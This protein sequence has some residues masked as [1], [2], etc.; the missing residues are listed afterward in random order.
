MTAVLTSILEL[1]STNPLVALTLKATFLLA[2]GSVLALGLRRSAAASRH[3][4]WMLTLS[5]VVALAVASVFVPT[6]PIPVS[7]LAAAAAPLVDATDVARPIMVGTGTEVVTIRLEND[8][9][10]TSA[11]GVPAT[12]A[13]TTPAGDGLSRLAGLVPGIWF[14]GVALVAFRLLLGQAGLVRLLRGAKPVAVEASEWKDLGLGPLPAVRFFRSPR[15]GSPLTWGFLRPVVLLPE[16]ADSW[17]ADRRRVVLVHELAHVER[18]DSLAQ[19]IAGVACA[20]YWFHPLVWHAARRL[21]L[22][23]EK[24]CDDRVLSTGTPG[25]DYA[26]HLIDVARHSQEVGIDGL[27][28]IG[29]ARRSQFEGRLLA[30]L[31]EC[32]PRGVPRLRGRAT[33]WVLSALVVLPLSAGRLVAP[34]VAESIES[35]APPAARAVPP[36]ATEA[37]DDLAQKS[38][39]SRQRNRNTG[40][41]DFDRTLPAKAGETLILNLDSGGSIHVSGWNEPQVSV[42]VRLGGQDWR[43]TEIEFERDGADLLLHSYQAVDRGSSS[44]SHHFEI[45]VP[46][47]FN[48]EIQSAGGEI[49]LEDLEGDFSGNTGGGRVSIRKVEGRTKITTGGGEIEVIDSNLDGRVS[50]G[51]GMVKLSRVRGGLRG[52]SGSGPVIYI[53][54]EG[55]EKED[56]DGVEIDVDGTHVTV[57]TYGD[58][59][60]GKDRDGHH[61]DIDP[62]GVIHIE[63]AG[64]PIVLREA[65]Q[66]ADVRTGGGDIRVGE[67]GGPVKA[68]TGGGRIEIGPVS[69]PVRASTGSGDIEVIVA[70]GRGDQSVSVSSGNGS[71]VIELPADFSGAFELETAYTNNHRKTRIESDWEL[72]RR[73][74]EHWDDSHGTPRKLVQARGEIGN[75]ESLISVR[76]VNGDIMI[77]KGR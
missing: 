38:D 28:A 48:L 18:R 21:R 8:S 29:M 23:S 58:G 47:R 46:R 51:G 20:V 36:A 30:I 4:A 37:L 16:D 22:E 64:G 42:R 49:D 10:V 44:T 41:Y 50:T 52:S 5:S 67:A 12:T 54:S 6:L 19:W 7:S 56:L 63:K 71:A 60:E 57:R 2:A 13:A 14:F 33:S 27:L 74:S 40:D 11:A 24:A 1:A 55:D 32:R 65:P 68:T 15:V 72:E 70:R 76:I 43:D 53:E 59:H 26:V 77:R 17:P 73:E 35:V 39:Y 61:E 34:A 66:G 9:D 3:L 31:D 62:S 69:G 45:R 25:A 75:G